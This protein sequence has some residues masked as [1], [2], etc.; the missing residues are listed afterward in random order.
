MGGHVTQKG[1]SRCILGI[2]NSQLGMLG[3][4]CFIQEAGGSLTGAGIHLWLVRG[5]S[6]LATEQGA[7]LPPKTTVSLMTL[8]IVWIDCCQSL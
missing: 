7:S 6:A 8:L 5:P 2:G 1:Q 3:Q 4:K